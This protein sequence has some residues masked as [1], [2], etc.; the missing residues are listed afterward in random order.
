MTHDT[1]SVYY[2]NCGGIRSKL[3]ELYLNIL[4]N[5]YDII[6]LAE[7]WLLPGIMD[8]EYIDD[9][10]TVYGRDKD[11]HTSDKCKGGGVIVAL[12]SDYVGFRRTDCENIELEEIILNLSIGKRKLI[13]CAVYLP[14]DLP[15]SK[16]ELHFVNLQNMYTDQNDHKICIVGDYNIPTIDWQR[17]DNFCTPILTNTS[18]VA[19]MALNSLSYM[20]LKQYNYVKNYKGRV[21]DLVLTNMDCTLSASDPLLNED[22][23]HPALAFTIACNA[24]VLLPV[25][26]RKKYNYRK[27]DYQLINKSV[28]TVDWNNELK[29]LSTESAVTRF[30]DQ[31]FNIIDAL[32]PQ[33]TFRS[34]KY[35]IWFTRE[36][37]QLSNRKERAWVKWKTYDSVSTYKDFSDLRSCFKRLSRQCHRS[38]ITNTEKLIKT[39]IKGFWSYASSL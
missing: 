25:K 39:N 27:A 22:R 15:F 8:T 33:K 5:N 20:H 37:I 14:P 36:L 21:I 35:P 7:T 32:V 31:I 11:T 34:A 4:S 2:Q 9:R 38:Y 12:R 10:Y 19:R 1:L 23:N 3:E 6:V 24:N 29:A 13:F 17:R 30:Y 26:P 18:L 16:Y 28:S